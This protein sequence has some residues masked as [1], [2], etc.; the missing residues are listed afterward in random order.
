MAASL[1]SP[2]VVRPSPDLDAVGGA[3]AVPDGAKGGSQVERSRLLQGWGRE[4]EK[5][6]VC[7]RVG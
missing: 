2:P 4:R 6:F 1:T 7:Q 3:L 5:P